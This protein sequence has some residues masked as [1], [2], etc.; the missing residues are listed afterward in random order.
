MHGL[1]M[2]L[3]MPIKPRFL[4]NGDA[5]ELLQGLYH[6]EGLPWGPVTQPKEQPD[7]TA[8]SGDRVFKDW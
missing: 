3:M 1:G 6:K 8:T 7:S 4:A 5:L 2:K